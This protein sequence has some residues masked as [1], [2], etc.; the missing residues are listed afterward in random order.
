MTDPTEEKLPFV[1]PNCGKYFGWGDGS[2]TPILLG[3]VNTV[4][5]NNKP[6]PCCGHKISGVITRD[7]E[8]ILS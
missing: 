2:A 1:C 5:F 3:I 4:P 7:L 6:T 8:M